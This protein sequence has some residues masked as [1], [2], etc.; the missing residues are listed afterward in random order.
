M[1]FEMS[2]PSTLP[3]SSFVMGYEMETA[4]DTVDFMPMVDMFMTKAIGLFD[5][6][7]T[8]DATVPVHNFDTKVR[9]NMV[10]I[11]ER[12][13]SMKHPNKTDALEICFSVLEQFER[14]AFLISLQ[15]NRQFWNFTRSTK[16]RST[17]RCRKQ[18]RRL[19]RSRSRSLSRSIT[20]DIDTIIEQ[21]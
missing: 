8:A 5:K 4:T 10:N 6:Y 3:L 16:K 19:S 13:E 14:A 17:R 20:P 7:L 11:F 2:L 15:L 9:N 1:S 12:Y 18:G 21:K